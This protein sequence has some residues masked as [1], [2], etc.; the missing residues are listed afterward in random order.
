[1][2]PF[3][4]GIEDTS[5]AA[6]VL[7]VAAAFLTLYLA[8]LPASLLRS[9]VKTLAVALL[10]VLAFVQQAHWLLVGALALSAAGDAFLS[11]PGDRAF[12]AGLASFLV[13]HVLYIALFALSGGGVQTLFSARAGLAVAMLLA[14]FLI[15]R[16]LLPKVDSDLKLPVSI[17]TAAIAAMGLAALTV[18][19]WAIVAGAILFMVSDS[20]LAWEKFLLPAGARSGAAMRRAVWI[21]YYAAQVLMTLGFLLS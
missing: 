20:I 3:P 21:T 9:L 8:D 12:L 17:Y 15:A 2:M 14:V 19:N 4:G 11:R 6:L 5:N 1:M 18:G 10:S 7:S 13:A 16:R